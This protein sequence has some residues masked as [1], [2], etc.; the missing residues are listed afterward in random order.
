M[1]KEALIAEK[2]ADR[3][4]TGKRRLISVPR[5]LLDEVGEVFVKKYDGSFT[6]FGLGKAICQRDQSAPL[7]TI[8]KK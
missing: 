1:S 4:A 5:Y 6:W 7:K 2:F 3:I 8:N